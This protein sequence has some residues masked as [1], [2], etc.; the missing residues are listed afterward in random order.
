M[1]F[2]FGSSDFIGHMLL[3]Y[4]RAKQMKAEKAKLKDADAD[5]DYESIEQSKVKE[6]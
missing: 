6:A 3:N 5:A 2:D 1:D 4:R